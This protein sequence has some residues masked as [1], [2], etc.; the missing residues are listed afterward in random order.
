[1][2]PNEYYRR[3]PIKILILWIN[4]EARPSWPSKSGQDARALGLFHNFSLLLTGKLFLIFFG[5]SLFPA[6]SSWAAT[7]DPTIYRSYSATQVWAYGL[8]D[9]YPNLVKVVQYGVSS[10]YHNPLLAIEITSNVQVNDTSKSD[11]LFTAGIHAGSYRLRGRRR[12]RQ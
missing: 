1:M 4:M 12:H 10:V 5:L 6:A 2:L 3:N 9:Q 7:F 8:A 11:F